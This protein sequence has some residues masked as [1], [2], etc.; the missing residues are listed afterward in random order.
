MK[1]EPQSRRKLIDTYRRALSVKNRMRCD[2]SEKNP[3]L[4]DAK[5]RTA[6]CY[7]SFLL[8]NKQRTLSFNPKM[9]FIKRHKLVI[10]ETIDITD[11]PVS[12][13]EAFVD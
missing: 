2:F 13:E 5:H 11:L 1:A 4:P 9:L 3:A 6:V 12:K 8:Q 10:I 7:P